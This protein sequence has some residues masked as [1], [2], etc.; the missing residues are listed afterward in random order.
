M[1]L[2]SRYVTRQIVPWCLLALTA[3][4]FIFLSTQLIRVA[5]IF[6]G[7]DIA[8]GE[9][10]KA[11][12]LLIVPI[13]GWALTP[14]FVVAVFATASRMAVDGEFVAR[15]SVGLSRWGLAAGPISLAFGLT[16]ASGWL[17]LDAAPRSQSALRSLAVE[18]AGRAIVGSIKAPGFTELSPSIVFFAERKNA[19]GSF[20]NVMIEDARDKTHPVQLFGS[21]AELRT[22]N[23]GG[24]LS[25]RM[26]Q[27]NAFLLLQQPAAVSFEHLSL[28]IQLDQ[29]MNRRLDFLPSLL[30]VSTREL[31]G[32]PPPGVDHNKW[33]YALWR[34]FSA[35]LGFLALAV[36][37]VFFAFGANWRGRGLPA[38]LAAG[39][40][41]IYHLLVRAAEGWAL[42][43]SLPPAWAALLPAICVT[44]Y[45]V[46]SLVFRRLGSGSK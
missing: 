46:I 19:N 33:G 34:R 36:L 38:A 14:A 5:P 35:P 42:K 25:I 15:D 45:L 20:E 39:C 2:L 23:K 4:I 7:A 21:R 8:P 32:P 31:T 41:L 10:F 27:G 43:G 26:N 6:N 11:L 24:F 16:L 29:I 17:W 18:L 3:C 1:F 28:D 44:I 22:E 37:S 30:A 12:F 13:L 9:A 40:F